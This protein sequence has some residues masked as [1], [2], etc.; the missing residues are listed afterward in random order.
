MLTVNPPELSCR[1]LLVGLV[2]KVWL[3]PSAGP[4]HWSATGLDVCNQCCQGHAEVRRPHGHWSCRWVLQAFYIPLPI[5]L[6]WQENL[7]RK[8]ERREANG[9]TDYRSIT[10]CVII[11]RWSPKHWWNLTVD[12]VPSFSIEMDESSYMTDY[13]QRC[14]CPI[15]RTMFRRRFCQLALKQ[16]RSSSLWMILFHIHRGRWLHKREILFLG[17]FR[18]CILAQFWGKILKYC[19]KNILHTWWGGKV[20]IKSKCNKRSVETDKA[21]KLINRLI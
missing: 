7:S 16:D 19:K 13:S 8:P 17:A 14:M 11:C 5:F 12:D 10:L 9:H 20:A 2:D 3:P 1:F 21:N 18:I 15:W 4:F 6:G